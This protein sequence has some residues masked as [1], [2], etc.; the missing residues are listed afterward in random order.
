VSEDEV[1]SPWFRELLATRAARG[2]DFVCGIW[3]FLSRVG[4]GAEGMVVCVGDP[5]DW[6]LSPWYAAALKQG[7]NSDSPLRRPEGRK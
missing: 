4:V 7:G 6:E 2:G 3:D 5:G 1:Q